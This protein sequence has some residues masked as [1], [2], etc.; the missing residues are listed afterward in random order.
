[1]TSLVQSVGARRRGLS[2]TSAD[3]IVIVVASLTIALLAQVAV[4]LPFTPVPVTGQTLGVLLVGGAFGARRGVAAVLLYLA[5]G[6]VGL[7]FF[8]SGSHG[9]DLLALTSATGGYLWGFAVAALILGLLADRGW[10]RSVRSS[11]GAM[12]IGEIIIFAFG[13]TWLSHAFGLPAEKA[14]QEGL[15][16]FLVGDVVKLLVAAGSLP[17][18]WRLLGGR[19]RRPLPIR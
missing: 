1:M 6:A 14:M 8:A 15:Y 11:L 12:L 3:L 13:V 19:E 4:H 17:A 16:P 18:F 9:V 5:E 10:N 7:P 2:S